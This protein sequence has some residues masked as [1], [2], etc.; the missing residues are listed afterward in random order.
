MIFSKHYYRCVEIQA[1]GLFS[2]RDEVNPTIL[3]GQTEVSAAIFFFASLRPLR[4]NIADMSNLGKLQCVAGE[5]ISPAATSVPALPVEFCTAAQLTF[6]SPVYSPPATPGVLVVPSSPDQPIQTQISDKDG[7]GFPDYYEVARNTDPNNS[8]SHPP[9]AER[10]FVRGILRTRMG[11]MFK[12]LQ[13]TGEN[14]NDW[15]IQLDIAEGGKTRA[16][17]VK[18]NSTVTVDGKQYKIIDCVPKKKKIF[19]EKLKKEIEK[20]LSEVTL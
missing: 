19:D 2:R 10:L 5:Y 3:T 11:V 7:D 6:V 8:L 1:P 13:M 9:L 16:V 15:N 18:L 12:G 14:R 20:D 17:F 4:K